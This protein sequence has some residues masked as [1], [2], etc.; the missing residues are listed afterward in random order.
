MLKRMNW[1]EMSLRW[2]LILN[3]SI[4]KI[5]VKIRFIKFVVK[6]LYERDKAYN[7]VLQ[8][9]VDPKGDFNR[10]NLYL[11]L[12]RGIKNSLESKNMCIW[13]ERKLK[14]PIWH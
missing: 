10:N 8:K 9:F 2:K 4:G 11:T 1:I 3:T 6:F 5:S 13:E 7:G 14:R 12:N